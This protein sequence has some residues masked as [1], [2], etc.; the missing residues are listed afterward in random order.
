[1]KPFHLLLL[2]LPLVFAACQ[3]SESVPPS[4][5]FDAINYDPPA[6][7]LP[8]S[9]SAS[10]VGLHQYI[11]SVSCAVPGCHDG[12]FEPD[13][14]TVQSTYSTLLYQPV[15]KNTSD[16]RFR[17]RIVPYDVQNSWLHYRVTTDDQVLGRM[18]LY[19]NPLSSGAIDKIA[20]WIA[21]GAP[22]LLGNASQFPDQQPQVTG[23][24]AFLDFNGFEYRVDTIRNQPF[25]PFGTLAGRELTLWIA[26]QDDSTT[27]ALLQNNEL[28]FS[29]TR[30]DFSAAVS[31]TAVY[32]ATPKIV[33][34]YFG[35]GNPGEFYWKVVINT[36]D[37]P[38]NEVT[39]FRYYTQ[40]AHHTEV[41]EFPRDTHPLEYQFFMSFF[42]AQ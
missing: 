15:I 24:A 11:F 33:P 1:M 23:V 26:V 18:P 38:V 42:V 7:S 14:R 5:P 20:S 13:F 22:D 40:D 31:R 37:F 10:L 4:N 12:S 29:A 39:F 32:S 36:G 17:F 16:E 21:A 30:D 41:M 2:L 8:A 35:P 28:K 9:D 3:H 25:A 27:L 19:D 34:D 6:V